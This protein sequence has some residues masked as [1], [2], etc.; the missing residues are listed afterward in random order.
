MKKDTA[1]V[2][3][4]AKRQG[5]QLMGRWVVVVA[6]EHL[7]PAASYWKRQINLMAKAWAHSE[8]LSRMIFDS[9]DGIYFPGFVVEK[10]MVLFI[11]A[12]TYSPDSHD[13]L[14]RLK[15]ELMVEG[16]NTDLYL[17]KGKGSL[18]NLLSVLQFGDFMAYYLATGYQVDPGARV[19]TDLFKGM[20]GF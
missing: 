10:L 9:V 1:A 3:N 12:D 2:G 5:G 20:P 18:A 13:L 16:I 4:P 8:G 7:T 6:A 17:A 11:D 14:G 15:Q 19:M